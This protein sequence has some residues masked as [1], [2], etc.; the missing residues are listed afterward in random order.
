V[1]LFSRCLIL[2]AY[3][4]NDTLFLKVLHPYLSGGGMPP[5]GRLWP[6]FQSLD[7]SYV[8][9]GFQ[10]ALCFRLHKPFFG[11][12]NG[13]ARWHH[14]V[15]VTLQIRKLGMKSLLRSAIVVGAMAAAVAL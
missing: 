15:Q 4:A 3:V 14:A 10:Q 12:I 1:A 7:A 13:S 5:F 8:L 6:P 2:C 11:R 9:L